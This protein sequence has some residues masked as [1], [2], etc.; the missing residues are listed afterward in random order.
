[1]PIIFDART[2]TDHFHGIGR[3]VAGLSGAL[4]GVAPDLDLVL[5][6]D[7]TAHTTRLSL[8]ALP[9]IEC[10]VSPFSIRQQWVVP[11][12]LRRQSAAL[13]HSPYYLMP[14]RPGV[15]AVLT[16][17]DLI[18]LLY[19]EY[20]SAAQRLIYRLAHRLALRATQVILS[21]SEA[22]RTDLVRCFHVDARR[23][24]VTPLAADARFAPKSSEHIAAARRKHD[25]PQAYVLYFG[26]NKPHKNLGRLIQAWNL[27][28]SEVGSGD[29]VL[30]I[31]GHWDRRYTEAKRLV[32]ALGLKE[33]V[34][35]L[36][37]VD[38]ADLPALYSGARLFV[39]PSLYEG[40]GLPVLEA[41]ACGAPVACSASSSLPEVAG[42]A[43]LTFDPR[44]V[45]G[46]AATIQ[47][48]LA[49]PG[50]R[51]HLR[52]QGL[53]RAAQFTWERTARTTLEVYRAI[54]RRSRALPTRF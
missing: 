46:M 9:R 8:P 17:Y 10:A 49:D 18:P 35:F 27:R 1:M 16:C 26:S 36:G 30:A 39:F 43:G 34:V 45:E 12:L 21:I 3:Y 41:M 40:F 28:C 2:A 29:L 7:P 44:D 53:E 33:R 11:G 23:I 25:L 20:Y 54:G 6:R 19:P 5:L 15:P 32:E 48:T 38:E 24:A 14:Y 52:Q 31:A 47:R 13:Y 4:Q 37:P 22:T 50:L 51:V 42:D